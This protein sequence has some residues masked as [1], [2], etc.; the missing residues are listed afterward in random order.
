MNLLNAELE[1]NW[2][3]LIQQLSEQFG[4]GEELNLQGVLFLI[5][6]QE[7]GKGHQK[8]SKDQKVDL[9]HVAIC[10]LLSQ[11]G[12]YEYEGRDK[13]GWPHW[14]TVEKLPHLKPGQQMQIVKQAII[15]YFNTSP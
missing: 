4:D 13:D 8:F 1:K 11:Y 10:R 6:V 15:E 7:F 3:Q 9:M 2:K 5:G 12:Y 14:K